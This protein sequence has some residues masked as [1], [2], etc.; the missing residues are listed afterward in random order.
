M[1]Q[2]L[3]ASGA[4][5]ALPLKTAEDAAERSELGLWDAVSIIIGIVI[6][7]GIYDTVLFVLA[8][9]KSPLHALGV[10]ALGRCVVADWSRTVM[11]SWQ[12]PIRAPVATTCT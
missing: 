9:V 5:P 12:A 1:L 6:G 4:P 10:W 8:N 11:P 2:D 7:A 3:E